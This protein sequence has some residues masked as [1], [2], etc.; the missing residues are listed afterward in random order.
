MAMAAGAY[1]AFPSEAALLLS[2]SGPLSGTPCGPGIAN[3]E[4]LVSSSPP[5]S[6]AG[7]YADGGRWPSLSTAEVHHRLDAVDLADS[8]TEQPSLVTSRSQGFV[9]VRSQSNLTRRHGSAG[10][11]VDQSP[12]VAAAGSTPPSLGGFSQGLV[13]LYQDC[14]PPSSPHHQQTTYSVSSSSSNNNN[15]TSSN[16]SS[17]KKTQSYRPFDLLRRLTGTSYVFR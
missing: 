8:S 14:S 13:P 4:A 1:V 5:R 2:V 17:F 10:G 12:P 16:S 9:D 7:I 6:A 15:N 11:G 3:H